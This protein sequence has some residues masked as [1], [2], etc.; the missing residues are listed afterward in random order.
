MDDELIRALPV[1]GTLDD[2]VDISNPFPNSAE[3]YLLR[4]RWEAQQYPDVMSVHQ[5]IEVDDQNVC[6]VH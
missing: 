3:Q 5:R 1:E 6:F 4:V 2:I